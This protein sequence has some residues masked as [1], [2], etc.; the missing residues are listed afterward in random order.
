MP[1]SC[2]RRR[3]WHK[4][5]VALAALVM[6]LAAAVP[7]RSANEVLNIVLDHATLVK[8]PERVATLVVGNPL[9]ADVS[10]Q[11]GGVMVV[12]GKGYG[13]TN[14]LV[15]DRTGTVLMEKSVHVRAPR[16]TVIV[17]RGTERETFSCTPQCEHRMM[18]GDSQ[19]V[20]QQVVAQTSARNA[21]AQGAAR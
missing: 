16:D 1:S 21:Q 6:S 4:R 11:T 3:P 9:I 15:L 17:Y 19:N 12:T 2:V 8:L 10:L 5:T 18:L 20:F 13:V 14:L 7:A